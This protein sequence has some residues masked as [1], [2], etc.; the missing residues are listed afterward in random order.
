MRNKDCIINV[1][2][3]KGRSQVGVGEWVTWNG[4]AGVMRV[5]A[6]M[7]TPLASSIDSRSMRA[8]SPMSTSNARIEP[9]GT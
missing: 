8:L 9:S 1:L 5:R 2:R 6:V 7:L 3:T 4:G